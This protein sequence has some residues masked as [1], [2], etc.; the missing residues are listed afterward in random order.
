MT[1][2]GIT[3]SD[4]V[5]DEGS[6]ERYTESQYTKFGG[7][8]LDWGRVKEILRDLGQRLRAAVNAV[9]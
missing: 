6:Y 8:P 2:S 9:R 1:D 5:V 3:E 4:V 7:E